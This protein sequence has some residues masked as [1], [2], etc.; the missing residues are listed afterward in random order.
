MKN[1]F[2]V[3]SYSKF[4]KNENIILNFNKDY[5]FLKDVLQNAH[6]LDGNQPLG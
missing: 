1:N 2:S 5:D 3:M 6:Y 4:L